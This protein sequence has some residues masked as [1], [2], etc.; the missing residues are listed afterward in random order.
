MACVTPSPKDFDYVIVGAGAIGGTVGAR[1]ARRGRR[2][3]FCDTSREHVDV[4]NRAGIRIEGPVEQF[5]ARAEAVTPDG[6]PERLDRVILA[7]KAQHTSAA[8][9][10]LAPRLAPSGLV[11]SLQN[12]LNEPLIAAAVGAGRTVGGFVNFGADYLEPGLI[13]FGG[14]GA[15]YI[16]ELDGSQS[17]RVARLVAEIDHAR[18]TANIFG[19][20]WA[21]LAYGAMLAATAVSDLTMA[22]AFDERRYRPLFVALAHEVLTQAQATPEPFDGFEPDDLEGSIARLA[23]FNRSSGKAH[24]G[25]YRDLAVRRRPTEVEALLGTIETPLVR[26]VREMIGEIEAGTRVVALANLDELTAAGLTA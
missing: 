3:L 4:I 12:G 18:P 24:S 7:V 16:G 19:Y 17:S 25:I 20:L 11:L 21:K 2:V 6:L 1:L 22:E 5:T 13:F 23:K 10:P 9:L 8:L 14:H 15:F 26:R